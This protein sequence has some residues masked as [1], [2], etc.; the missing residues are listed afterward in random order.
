MFHRAGLRSEKR[1]GWGLL[2]GT[3]TPPLHPHPFRGLRGPGCWGQDTEEAAPE[4]DMLA[5]GTGRG[6]GG[7]GE[8]Q[9]GRPAPLIAPPGRP[10]APCLCTTCRMERLRVHSARWVW[11]PCRK[12]P[13]YPHR[14]CA[15][16]PP[17]CIW[18][19]PGAWK[20]GTQT[21]SVCR[22][23]TPGYTDSSGTVAGILQTGVHTLP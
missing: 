13:P 15:S 6:V 4:L 9:A 18:H 20:Q 17:L 1:L 7:W 10:A 3:D 12:A 21:M 5:L 23:L 19:A 2:G 8:R 11:N 22:K 16:A 14:S